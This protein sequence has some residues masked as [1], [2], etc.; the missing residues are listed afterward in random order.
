MLMWWSLV[1][2]MG[3]GLIILHELLVWME[4]KTV[5]LLLLSIIVV[6][7]LIALIVKFTDWSIKNAIS[8]EFIVIK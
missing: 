3:L 1:S 6:I 5:V 8:L 2:T 7:D 4:W